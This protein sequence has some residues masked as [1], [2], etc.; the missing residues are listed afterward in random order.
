VLWNAGLDTATCLYSGGLGLDPRR[1][2]TE[3]GASVLRIERQL[4][5]RRRLPDGRHLK[6]AVTV[7]RVA[8]PNHPEGSGPKLAGC[9]VRLITIFLRKVLRLLLLLWE[10]ASG[11]AH[12]SWPDVVTVM[13]SSTACNE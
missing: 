7:E 1:P 3:N 13:G 9:P 10:L 12:D 4:G 11:K 6:D 8:E 5:D 2:G